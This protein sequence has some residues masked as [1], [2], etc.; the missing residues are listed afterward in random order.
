MRTIPVITDDSQPYTR[1]HLA[2]VPIWPKYRERGYPMRPV[3]SACRI[4]RP[5]AV[6]T[7]DGLKRCADGYL[8]VD[9]MGFPIAV[10]KVRF[11]RVY[12]SV[13]RKPGVIAKLLNPCGRADLY[14]NLKSRLR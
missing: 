5:F 3:I 9:A 8:C 11:E 13:E 7:F 6:E 14:T 1:D 4:D 12:E 2:N 10:D